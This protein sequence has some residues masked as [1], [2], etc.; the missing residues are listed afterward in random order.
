[1]W[2]INSK[3]QGLRL[4]DI[5][6]IEPDSSIKRRS[7]A[8]K[9]LAPIRSDLTG[10]IETKKRLREI[11][12]YSLIHQEN[13]ISE[14]TSRLAYLPDLDVTVTADAGQAVKTITE[15]SLNRPIAIN[16]SAVVMRELVPLLL[17]TDANV[18]ETYCNEF[19]PFENRFK[20]YWQPPEIMFESLSGSFAHSTNMTALRSESIAK[21][22]V[23]DFVGLLGVNAISAREG[24]VVFLQHMENI[25]RII[26]EA[27]E[28]ILVASLDKI[29]GDLN[30][31]VFQTK[32]MAIFGAGSL[33]LTFPDKTW[34]TFGIEE[35]PF[36]SPP[37]VPSKI[38][39]ILLD[40][41][42][43]RLLH[44][45][46]RDLLACISC[47]ACA[48]YCP[49]SRFFANGAGWSPKEY[50][51]FFISGK[52]PSLGNCLQ[53]QN[54]KANCPLNIDLPGMILEAKR[55]K[56]K[57]RRTFT[58]VLLSNAETAERLGVYVP[59]AVRL[60]SANRLLRWLGEKVVGISRQR[61]IP[62]LQHQTF[63]RWFH[64]SRK[65]QTENVKGK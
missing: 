27:G 60:V 5:I 28:V 18:V 38:H 9:F 53:C 17:D 35:I 64:D 22:G 43:S 63:A 55:Q 23:K 61:P 65:G 25:G 39:L 14:M 31:A 42:R 58:E 10:L 41:G 52:N 49:A 32:C 21:N 44:S 48:R 8:K 56:P 29:T 57:G 34:N 13:L 20:E 40:N 7:C 47:R 46:Y 19:K 15:I 50:L 24:A 12:D 33:P 36:Q 2:L 3:Q 51:H 30:S 1:M 4:P 16:K 37:H 6:L 54:C 11:R 62:E 59:G 26:K 45:Q